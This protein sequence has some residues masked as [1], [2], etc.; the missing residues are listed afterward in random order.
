V[1]PGLVWKRTTHRFPH[2][3]QTEFSGRGFSDFDLAPPMP[4][5]KAPTE[6]TFIQRLENI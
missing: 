4:A 2:R 3:L 5:A 6:Q 1:Q